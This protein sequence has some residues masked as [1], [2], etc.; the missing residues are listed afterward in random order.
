MNW[1][2]NWKLVYMEN[3]AVNSDD[4]RREI[5]TSLSMV[6]FI[7]PILRILH[8]LKSIGHS[9]IHSKGSVNGY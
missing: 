4:F 5:A 1:I 6:A 3:L 7:S 8:L 2:F 9:L